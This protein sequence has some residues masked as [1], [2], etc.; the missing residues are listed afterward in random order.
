MWIVKNLLRGT[1]SFRGMGFSIPPSGEYDLDSLGRQVA[2][3]SN[4]LVVAFEEGYLQNIFKDQGAP[5]RKGPDIQA[6]ITA[7]ELDDRLLKYKQE[8][9]SEFKVLLGSVGGKEDLDNL[10][11]GIVGDV[12]E[13]FDGL[14]VAKLKLDAE[15]KRI[16]TDA[17]LSKAE[18]RA[19]LAFLEQQERD[20][21]ANFSKLGRQTS[22]QNGDDILDKADLLSN[23]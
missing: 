16:V 15:R 7:G 8:F 11:Q 10:K 2:E 19:R 13:M 1:L 6:G 4:Q 22:T 12:Q 21:K 14:K 17:S 20:L 18:I 5:L 3:G 23:I 9:F